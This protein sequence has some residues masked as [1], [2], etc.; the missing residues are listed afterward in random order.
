[1]YGTQ[2]LGCTAMLRCAFENDV[3]M[4]GTQAPGDG[5]G[6]KMRLRMM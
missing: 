3:N 1:M 6:I 5:K 2:A 4:Y